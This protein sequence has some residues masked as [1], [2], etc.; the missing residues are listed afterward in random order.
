M[1]DK[2]KSKLNVPGPVKTHSNSSSVS[3]AILD[4]RFRRGSAFS[5]MSQASTDSYATN[6]SFGFAVVRKSYDVDPASIA[7][8]REA[9]DKNFGGVPSSSTSFGSLLLDSEADDDANSSFD[10]DYEYTLGLEKQSLFS[11]TKN[12]SGSALSSRKGSIESFRRRSVSLP[13]KIW[14]LDQ[15][16][17]LSGKPA[18][19]I[20]FGRSASLPLITEY[21]RLASFPDSSHLETLPREIS[22][23]VEGVNLRHSQAS[24]KKLILQARARA[25]KERDR[26]NAR[27]IPYFKS[28]DEKEFYHKSDLLRDPLE[29]YDCFPP[30]LYLAGFLGVSYAG[31]VGSKRELGKLLSY[32][33][34][35]SDVSPHTKTVVEKCEARKL[36]AQKKKSEF[37]R[38]AHQRQ[39]QGKATTPTAENKKVVYRKLDAKEPILSVVIEHSRSNSEDSRISLGSEYSE[40]SEHGGT[41][42]PSTS[43]APEKSDGA[44]NLQSERRPSREETH[45]KLKQ[46]EQDF[47]SKQIGKTRSNSLVD[48]APLETPNVQKRRS[49]FSI[50][51]WK[52]PETNDDEEEKENENDEEK[53][54]LVKEKQKQRAEEKKALK[55]ATMS[56]VKEEDEEEGGISGITPSSSIASEGFSRERSMGDDLSE[57]VF[58]NLKNRRG[59]LP[60]TSQD[61]LRKLAELKPASEFIEKFA[62]SSQKQKGG[63]TISAQGLKQL[64]A[65]SGDAVIT[66]PLFNINS[67][68]FSDLNKEKE[69]VFKRKFGSISRSIEK[70][71]IKGD[72]NQ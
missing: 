34:D 21:G 15:N 22:Q 24:K 29:V 48:I 12:V 26:R 54:R 50:L 65:T 40:K 6:G 72:D 11:S 55:K 39:L 69:E 18:A 31:D 42:S 27:Q 37:L 35:L 9:Y 43:Q 63:W 67:I 38:R 58:K 62:E 32:P 1:S 68:D 41:D 20:N 2:Q 56:L 8:I 59:S 45:A 46:W 51:D 52:P 70:E 14:S 19:K 44:T 5:Y 57:N 17:N 30:L 49:S 13:D 53:L 60:L 64:Q 28:P 3:S 66:N 25:V 61:E 4:D 16:G 47:L 36:F 10:E 33:T 7:R 23:R 71:I